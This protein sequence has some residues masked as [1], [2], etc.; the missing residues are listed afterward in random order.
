MTDKYGGR[1]R[2][3]PPGWQ[4]QRDIGKSKERREN[5]EKKREKKIVNVGGFRFIFDQ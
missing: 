2:D 3:E 4:L 5:W 1:Q